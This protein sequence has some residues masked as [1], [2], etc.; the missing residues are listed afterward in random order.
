MVCQEA[1]W[2]VRRQAGSSGDRLVHQ[3]LEN[4]TVVE[5]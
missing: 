2:F 1:D 4:K 3:G 5:E